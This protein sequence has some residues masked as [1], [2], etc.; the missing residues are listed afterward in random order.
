M[1]PKT[2]KP[3]YTKTNEPEVLIVADGKEIV[4]VHKP[5]KKLALNN[6]ERAEKEK[7]WENTDF[8]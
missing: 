5:T 3:E 7:A 8:L 4:E 6:K 1:N 2:Y